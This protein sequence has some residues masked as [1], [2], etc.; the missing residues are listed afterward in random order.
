MRRESMKSLSTLGGILQL[1][2]QRPHWLPW[3]LTLG[4]KWISTS[5]FSC[6]QIRLHSHWFSCQILDW[7]GKALPPPL[8]ATQAVCVA[9]R[10]AWDLCLV[11]SA[12]SCP[13]PLLSHRTL[14]P[15][16]SSKVLPFF[17]ERAVVRFCFFLFCLFKIKI[18]YFLLLDSI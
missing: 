3:G 2:F 1:T 11:P 18:S 9:G 13:L 12:P 7:G 8:L 10:T 5:A 6:G 17:V 15:G 4:W 16:S 14:M